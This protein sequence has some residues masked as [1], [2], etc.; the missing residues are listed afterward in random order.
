MTDLSLWGFSPRMADAHAALGLPDTVPARVVA[1]P[2]GRWRVV[3]AFG[4]LLVEPAG[5]LRFDAADAADLPSVGDW[6]AVA[7]R[8]DEGRGTVVALLP[9]A[10]ALV[11]KA[12]GRAVAPQVLA[13]NLDLV[14]VA[15]GLDLDWNPARLER[16][17]AVVWESGAQPLVVLTKADACAD[18]AARV[19]EARRVAVGADVLAVSA[20]D[21]RG[22]DALRDA[23]PPATT[24]ALLGSSGVGK[25][26]L[27]NRL[28]GAAAQATTDVRAHD[29]RGRHTTTTREMFR[30]PWGA[31]LVDTPGLREVAVWT[32][33]DAVDA[34][35]AD[36]VALAQGCRFRD[37]AHGPEPGCAVR[38]AVA[39]GSLDASRLEDYLRLGREQA[40]LAR[41]A[42]P[43][44]ARA[45]RDRWK[46]IHRSA[47]EH[48]R[49]K[50]GE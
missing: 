8:P 23:L 20:Q 31:L 40:W 9:R 25:S 49:A 33:G 37:C 6:V 21:G 1:A 3:S 32:D 41:K 26:T 12:A 11:R 7:A 18:V 29:H 47:R 44:A 24:A 30:L 2:G 39:A 27:V 5:R 22:L 4:D 13:A 28:L 46:A 50:R 15:C 14:L 48:M 42:D 43:V 17:L 19:E 16:L 36:V 34:A 10:S 38:V 45:E 35:F